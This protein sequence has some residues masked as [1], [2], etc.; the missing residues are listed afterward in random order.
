MDFIFSNLSL[1]GALQVSALGPRDLSV[2]TVFATEAHLHLD[3]SP[4]SAPGPKTSIRLT[5]SARDQNS[6]ANY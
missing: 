6:T 1:P 2:S 5:T 3:A 4:P